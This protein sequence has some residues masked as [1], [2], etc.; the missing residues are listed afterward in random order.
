MKNLR[1]YII[2]LLSL[3]IVGAACSQTTPE[4][5]CRI[6]NGRLVVS[7][8]K[9][10]NTEQRKLVVDL[11]DLDSALVSKVFAGQLPVDAKWNSRR[12]NDNIVELSKPLKGE[13]S[14]SIGSNDVMILNDTW[15]K[16][17]IMD[18]QSEVFGVNRF[19][20][21]DVFRYDKGIARFFIPGKSNARQIYLA[22]SF[23]NWST[24]QLPLHKTDSGWV[25]SFKLSPG[26]YTYKYI[27]D[28]RWTNDNYNK[29]REDDG[30]AGHNSVVFCYN[31]TFRLRGHTD[32]RSVKV[33]GSFNNWNPDELKMIKMP[34]GWALE[35]YIREGTHAYK[36]LVDNNW[37]TDPYNKTVRPD[38]R[39]NFNSFF[40]LGDT[41]MFRLKGFPDAENVNLAGD[42]N[43]WNP[44][45]L[46]MLKTKTGWQLPYVLAAGNYA[47]K[48]IVD[49]K[50]IPDPGNPQQTGS[51]PDDNSFISFKPNYTFV[52]PGHQ[53]ASS[54]LVSGSFNNWSNSGYKMLKNNGKWTFQLYLRPGK[55]TYKLMVD[56][57]W[58]KDPS[59]PVW[60]A[61]EYGTGNSVLW[62]EP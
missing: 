10:W 21:A 37:I 22:G 17:A 16:E 13:N 52:Y 30:Q 54:V 39:G 20:S 41:L 38:G 61:N 47:Y 31:H 60:E 4:N 28:G 19:T 1:T 5:A 23:N 44:G 8:D 24:M 53:D 2:L 26:K 58:I 46:Y 27:V 11:F 25:A 35:A 62:I 7:L 56:G 51:G 43:A 6:A 3:V 55:Y 29:I 36:F 59:N 34:N 50:W 48:F 9:R 14:A 32:A 33:A 18:Q 40:G 45:E 42:F 57:K 12:V 49:G 15:L